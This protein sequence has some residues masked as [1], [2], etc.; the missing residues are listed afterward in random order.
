MGEDGRGEQLCRG[1]RSMFGVV[2]AHVLLQ[3]LHVIGQR[4][5]TE[6]SNN[7]HFNSYQI[8]HQVVRSEVPAMMVVR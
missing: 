7:N 3:M 2:C 8:V 6:A 4:A 5:S 1:N